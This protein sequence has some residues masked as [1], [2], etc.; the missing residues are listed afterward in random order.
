MDRTV[1]KVL[2]K[3]AEEALKVDETGE[4]CS[5]T[6]GRFLGREM[7]R[8]WWRGSSLIGTA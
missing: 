1:L 6:R 7:P 4:P 8:V 5:T 2:G 3:T